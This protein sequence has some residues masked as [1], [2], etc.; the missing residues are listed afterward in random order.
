MSQLIGPLAGQLEVLV[1][2]YLRLLDECVDDHDALPEKETVK[3]TA[4]AGTTAW[5]ELEQSL[6]QGTRVRQPKTW[7]MLCQELDQACVVS[8]D[9]DRPRL[10]LRQNAWVEIL[11]LVRHELC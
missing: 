9:V 7:P 11:D 10:D 4:D 1:R 2:R 6:A 8:N 3:T 5:P